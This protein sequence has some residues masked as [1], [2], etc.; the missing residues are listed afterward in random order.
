M[1]LLKN[2][3]V[4][5]TLRRYFKTAGANNSNI[6]SWKSEGLSDENIKPTATSNKML[7]LSVDYFI[8]KTRVKFNGDCLKQEKKFI[9]PWKNSEHL[10]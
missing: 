2:Y 5:Q 4:F 7:N 6:L 3:L 8:T 1:M 9:L 10:Y